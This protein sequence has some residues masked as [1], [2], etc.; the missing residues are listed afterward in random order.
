M[1]LVSTLC[2]SLVLL[3]G[4]A[5]TGGSL[6][7]QVPASLAVTDMEGVR[8]DLDAAL[9]NGRAVALVWWQTWCGSCLREA[10]A[11]AASARQNAGSVT[12][13]GIVPGTD[14]HVDDTEVRRVAE[15]LNLPYPTVR[16]RDLKLTSAFQVQGT[17]TIIV[18]AGQPAKVVYSGHE[19]PPDFSAFAAGGGR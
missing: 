4:C 8:H 7:V 3:V 1:R 11:L 19:A 18:L 13:V 17:P 6:P 10:P 12:F 16:D 5:A 2:T 14:D 15:S 9:A